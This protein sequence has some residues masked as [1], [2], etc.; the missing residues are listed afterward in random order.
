MQ[1][2]GGKFRQGPMIAHYI[3]QLLCPGDIY[4]EPFCG[5]LGVASRVN[6]PRMWMNDI[7]R[8]LILM[9]QGIFDG[10]ITEVDWPEMV[11]REEWKRRKYDRDDNDW[12][13]AAI[14]YGQSFN[15]RF[16][17]AW[18][19]YESTRRAR[20]SIETRLANLHG[21]EIRWTHG[22]Y[23]DMQFDDN[24][25]YVI[26]CDPPYEN[27]KKVHASGGRA[28]NHDAYYGWIAAQA[29]LGRRILVSGRDV[30]Y[31]GTWELVHDW[32]DTNPWYSRNGVKG[33]G[34]SEKLWIPKS[35]VAMLG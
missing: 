23:L 30:P 15:G 3:D 10:K 26:Y 4:V 5:M 6:W 27:A 34:P 21:T 17:E 18:V 16:Y 12:L 11:P 14:G 22:S 1:I 35:Q 20:Q 33:S 31:A 2:A 9:L 13:T 8:P 29:M 7:S 24:N 25:D 19:G 32:G 28:F